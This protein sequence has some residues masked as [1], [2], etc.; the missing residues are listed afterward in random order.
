MKRY[1]A[2]CLSLLLIAAI[3]PFSAF[4]ETN[5]A[6]LPVHE[7]LKLAPGTRHINTN[8]IVIDADPEGGYEG[9]YVVV[10][11]PSESSVKPV[12]TG[13][14][15]GL[16]DTTVNTNMLI[17]E[18]A[19]SMVDSD[20]PYIIDVDAL[21]TEVSQKYADCDIDAPEPT[22][23]SYSVGDTANFALMQYNPLANRNVEFKVLY[24]T[25]HCYIWTPTSTDANVY[26][27]TEDFAEIAAT[28]FESKYELMNASFGSH[29][30]GSGDGRVNI[31]YYNIDDG[32]TPGNPYSAGFFAPYDYSTYNKVPILHID[33]YP[34]VYRPNGDADLSRCYSTMVHEY[35]HMIHYSVAPRNDTWCNEMMSAAAEE[36]CYPGSSIVLRAASYTGC[37]YSPDAMNAP[38]KEYPS[39]NAHMHYGYTMYAFSNNIPDILALYGQVS[40]FAQYLYSR[41]ELG[42]GVFKALLTEIS[43][44]TSTK[45]QFQKVCPTVLGMSASDIV[46]DF[47]IAL[48]ANT[49]ASVLDGKYGFKLQS[50]YDPSLYYGIQNPYNI[51]GPIIFTENSCNINGGGAITIK[52]VG[53]VYTPPADAH[54]SLKYYGIKLNV[55][56]GNIEDEPRE[57]GMK[58]E[59]ET[60]I[61]EDGTFTI[62]TSAYFAGSDCPYD[63][64]YSLFDSISQSQ[65][66]YSTDTRYG[67]YFLPCVGIGADGKFIFSDT[68]VASVAGSSADIGVW[69]NMTQI[70]GINWA[71]NACSNDGSRYRGYKFV[72]FI[73]GVVFSDDDPTISKTPGSYSV[74][75]DYNW[76]GTMIDN[77]V[78]PYESIPDAEITITERYVP[79]DFGVNFGYTGGGSVISV[80]DRVRKCNPADTSVS[81][82]LT[83]VSLDYGTLN[84]ASPT[85]NTEK[86]TTMALLKNANGNCEWTRLTF[87]PATNVLY[88]DYCE[89]ITYTDGVANWSVIG[90]AGGNVQKSGGVFGYDASYANDTAASNGTAHTVAVTKDVLRG[91]I[92]G[93]KWPCAEFTFTG[94]GVDIIT[95]CGATTGSV[96][97]DIVPA[98][99]AYYYTGANSAHAIVDTSL[100]SEYGDLYQCPIYRCLDLAY[101][102]YKVMLRAIYFPSLNGASAIPGLE[103]VEYTLIDLEKK[104]VVMGGKELT[105]QLDAIRIYDPLGKNASEEAYA[106]FNESSPEYRN[107]RALVENDYTIT[108][109]SAMNLFFDGGIV[110]EGKS[111]LINSLNEIYV[112][113]TSSVAFNIG[114]DYSALHISLKSP[115]GKPVVVKINGEQFKD[116]TGRSIMIT[117]TTELYYDITEYIGANGEVSITCE[118]PSG[119]NYAAL[120]SLVNLKIIPDTS[121][122]EE[123]VRISAN[124]NLLGFVEAVNFGIT[125]D[126]N[127]DHSLDIVDAAAAMR[128][129]L[130]LIDRLDAYGEYCADV[131]CDGRIDIIDA[132]RILRMALG[133]EL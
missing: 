57:T 83:S 108:G 3:V 113:A 76:F 124:E 40:L 18:G 10:Y 25:D 41:S 117:H 115:T 14:M 45:N 116:E 38:P 20:C 133:I 97:I 128:R 15:S 102:S 8:D 23:A 34:G 58:F 52:P 95:L 80:N 65:F 75:G 90:A 61:E 27:L 88:E 82:A 63:T 94:T 78:T 37:T 74:L 131:N 12:S 31:L 123:P 21:M 68:P 46:R 98:D 54:G 17:G 36:L 87:L 7:G 29:S 120:L 99:K 72:F 81:G 96:A 62:V 56:G 118:L 122:S 19:E 130:G 22:R 53:G 24:K 104:Y 2:L 112:E 42:N 106:A 86:L 114:G 43:K 33:T 4:A 103:D 39:T 89:S 35:Q 50:G 49:S 70:S 44:T 47:R 107:V 67:Y 71:E 93:G 48:T 59:K 5:A 121:G 110:K 32:W 92:A 60:F 64:G 125:G 9:D 26:P 129:A 127:H 105:V 28:E 73:T 77:T 119:A 66:Q 79:Y 13:S 109:E 51:L 6:E 132:M 69:L 85:I 30:A 100:V 55:G 101:D 16:I 1:C 11:N 91:V 84:F 111:L 126:A